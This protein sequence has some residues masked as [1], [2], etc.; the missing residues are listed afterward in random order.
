M[1]IAL[2][3]FDPSRQYDAQKKF[4]CGNAVINKFV[5]DSLKGQVKKG[6]STAYVLTDSSAKDRFVGFYT[7]AQHRMSLKDLS[8]LQL[9]SLPSSVPCTRLIML[10]VDKGHQGKQL[11]MKLMKH[12][13][14]TTKVVAR[15]I[16]SVG[17]YLDADAAAL[18]FYERL[19]FT[20]LEGDKSPAPSPMF[21]PLSAI[22]DAH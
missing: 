11:G 8:A 19:G 17:L 15:S 14:E 9:G 12:A 4:D 3:L 10:G 20:L 21:L 16:A 1:T 5:Y 7:I 22:P 13:L 6:F 2:S 18:S